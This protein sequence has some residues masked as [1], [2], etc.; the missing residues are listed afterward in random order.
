MAIK[1]EC[2]EYL[3]LASAQVTFVR[4]WVNAMGQVDSLWWPRQIPQF[5]QLLD[6]ARKGSGRW[7]GERWQFK[8]ADCAKILAWI[9]R[10]FPAMSILAPDQEAPALNL[11]S[12]VE[13]QAVTRKM[14]ML[15][16]PADQ[17]GA[18]DIAELALGQKFLVEEGDRESFVWVGRKQD[19]RGF[20]HRLRDKGF[21]VHC[22]R[23]PGW[24]RLPPV[25]VVR[26][27][28]NVNLGL[29]ALHPG[30]GLCFAA[31][32]RSTWRRSAQAWT[33]RAQNCLLS[34]WAAKLEMMKGWGLAWQGDDPDAAWEIPVL[35]SQRIPGWDEPAE[36][37]GSLRE[38]QKAAVEFLA[39]RRWRG[40]IG[41]EMG[42][43]KTASAIATA[44][45]MD[46]QRIIVVCPTVLRHNWRSELLRWR[47]AEEGSRIL[48]AEDKSDLPDV[49]TRWMLV[50]YD[51]IIVRQE[52]WKAASKDEAREIIRF[53]SEHGLDVEADQEIFQ[54]ETALHGEPDLEPKRLAAWRKVQ[55]RLRGDY[56]QALRH[57][58]PDLVILDEAH[59]AK[60]HESKRHEAVVLLSKAA[61]GAVLLTGTPVQ[62]NTREPVTLL[63]IIDPSMMQEEQRKYSIDELKSMLQPMLLRRT[64]LEVLPE[65]PPKIHQVIDV[66]CNQLGN[67]E[68]VAYA[69]ERIFSVG[70]S[71]EVPEWAASDPDPEMRIL[72]AAWASGKAMSDFEKWRAALGTAKLGD[73]TFDVLLNT[74]DERRR[75]VVFAHHIPV[76]T[77]VTEAL[78]QHGW[79][80]A[81]L[82]GAVS[83]E[84]RHALAERFQSG[85]LDVLVCGMKAAGEGLNMHRADTVIFLELDWNPTVMLQAVDRIHRLGQAAES[86][87]V[88][89]LLSNNLLERFVRKLV[90]DRKLNMIQDV[91]DETVL[92]FAAANQQPAIPDNVIDIRSHIRKH[93]KAS[94]A[95]SMA[96]GGDLR[97][98]IPLFV[99][100]DKKSGVENPVVPSV[101]PHSA[102]ERSSGEE[103]SITSGGAVIG[104]TNSTGPFTSS[105]DENSLASGD[106]NCAVDDV[107]EPPRMRSSSSNP[108]PAAKPGRGRPP[109][110]DEERK[111]R[112]ARSRTAWK[113]ANKDKEIAWIREWQKRNPDRV[114]AASSRWRKKKKSPE[115]V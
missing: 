85:E 99:L 58:G 101:P 36:G 71:S 19:A 111:A 42:L 54:L 32:V 8:P 83:P 20:L 114:A 78:N 10:E 34:Q 97:V 48:I 73:Q 79:R 65:L 5:Q 87:H 88:I 45:A 9:G 63:E 28:W 82:T 98:P 23:Y 61:D 91:L 6:R 94:D 11:A 27:G 14:W 37:I 2:V 115:E 51:Q 56:L 96:V 105:G 92:L 59:R 47:G 81:A 86:C 112:R 44:A 33:F 70:E 64:K 25:T 60:N 46:A 102:D 3:R 1:Y 113:A 22:R 74:L 16:V 18:R 29:S 106:E 12:L 57:W 108:E 35:E 55:S 67:E 80:A 4:T 75:L 17:V 31:P 49:D 26:K 109:L 100:R 77:Q 13:L 69:I 76:I 39:S 103:N 104:D 38:Y 90:L 53:L 68:S 95:Q 40:L 72:A 21:S 93:K 41:D 107:D 52:R 66:P 84:D 30:H 43:G 7:N 24:R 110:S 50:S 62:N 15:R 89:H